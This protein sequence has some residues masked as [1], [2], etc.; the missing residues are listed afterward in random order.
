MDAITGDLNSLS[1][2]S[3][4]DGTEMN[5]T[6]LSDRFFAWLNTEPVKL[7][8]EKALLKLDGYFVPMP[9]RRF[10]I[11][12]I[13]HGL[14]VLFESSS[15]ESPSNIEKISS[16]R[17]SKLCLL[18]PGYIAKGSRLEI[19]S[20]LEDIVD[21]NCRKMSNELIWTTE[22]I[23]DAFTILGVSKIIEDI[24]REVGVHSWRVSG[25]RHRRILATSDVHQQQFEEAFR[26]NWSC[27]DFTAESV[28][29]IISFNRGPRQDFTLDCS[30]GQWTKHFGNSFGNGTVG[31]FLHVN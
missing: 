1:V 26:K 17:K 29:E 11:K 24:F 21:N 31:G 27:K 3:R 5:N 25:T 16:Y 10:M 28:L 2:A 19:K 8:R 9:F 20:C 13:D 18:Q 23:A 14:D 4:E 6:L 22:E 30:Q 15:V 7:A 12:I